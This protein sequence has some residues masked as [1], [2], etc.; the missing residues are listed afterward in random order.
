MCVFFCSSQAAAPRVNPI[1]DVCVHSCVL[2][3]RLRL[4]G[5]GTGEGGEEAR[6]EGEG[7]LVN[8]SQDLRARLAQVQS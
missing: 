5:D 7:G 4:S 6:E 8:E 1:S 3:R 2:R